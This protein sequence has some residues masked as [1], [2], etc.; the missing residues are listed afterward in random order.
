MHAVA[1]DC[2]VDLAATYVLSVIEHIM[3]LFQ[4]GHAVE[5]FGEGRA[6]ESF[7]SASTSSIT[8]VCAGCSEPIVPRLWSMASR[9]TA[10]AEPTV[11][12]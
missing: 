6:A 12:H 9:V 7:S 3:E 5:S 1:A 11:C 2:S 8:A 4:K 10:V